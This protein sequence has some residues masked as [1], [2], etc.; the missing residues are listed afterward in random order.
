M[1]RENEPKLKRITRVSTL[2]LPVL[3]FT[4]VSIVAVLVVV[5]YLTFTAPTASG[6]PFFGPTWS[7]SVTPDQ[8][9]AGVLTMQDKIVLVTA[10]V[11]F[12]AFAIPGL[13]FAIRLIRCFKRH[14]VFSS[15][16]ARYARLVAY[17]YLAYTVIAFV[18]AVLTSWTPDGFN[19]HFNPYFFSKDVLIL[20]LLWLFVWTH[21]LGAALRLDSEMTI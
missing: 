6:D 10:I 1:R 11:V 13:W 21:E 17:L 5:P 4:L 12:S 8:I 19:V 2:L 18:A 15:V 14:D 9:A 7:L 20:G 3:Y 16:T